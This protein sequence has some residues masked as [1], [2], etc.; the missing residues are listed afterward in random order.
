MS[1]FIHNCGKLYLKTLP[2]MVTFSGTTGLLS[3]LGSYNEKQYEIPVHIR[4]IGYISIGI[5]TGVLYPISFPLCTY[6]LCKKTP[7]IEDVKK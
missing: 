6:Y 7:I 5:M 4:L 3:C 2:T 1:P